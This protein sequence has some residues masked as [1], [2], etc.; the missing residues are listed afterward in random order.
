MSII[1][2]STNINNWQQTY[3]IANNYTPSDLLTSHV[4]F[5]PNRMNS[6]RKITIITSTESIY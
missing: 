6:D 1:C 5:K 2:I 4:T 3:I